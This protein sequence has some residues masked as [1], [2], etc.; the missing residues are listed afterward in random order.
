MVSN[1]NNGSWNIDNITLTTRQIIPTCIDNIKYNPY[2]NKYRLYFIKYSFYLNKQS[3][4]LYLPVSFSNFTHIFSVFTHIAFYFTCVPHYLF[5]RSSLYPYSSKLS[6]TNNSCI[7][8]FISDTQKCNSSTFHLRNILYVGKIGKLPQ[9]IKW[10]TAASV[11][12]FQT[13]YWQEK[14]ILEPLNRNYVTFL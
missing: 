8:S 3:H 1:T 11:P 10:I 7:I 13:V 9:C 6:K 2:F 5:T 12:K 14:V 4:I